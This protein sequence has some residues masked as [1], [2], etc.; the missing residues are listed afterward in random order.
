[1]TGTSAKNSYGI[2]KSKRARCLAIK[3][4]L[5]AFNKNAYAVSNHSKYVT[6]SDVLFIVDNLWLSHFIYNTPAPADISHDEYSKFYEKLY[7]LWPN[8][9]NNDY[10]HNT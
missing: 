5:D 2:F 4:N 10:N 8:M 6:Y 3:Y 9:F 1:M 7:A